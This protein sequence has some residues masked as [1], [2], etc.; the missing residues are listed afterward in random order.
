MASGCIL[1]LSENKKEGRLWKQ[2]Q[3]YQD[4]FMTN[5][6]PRQIETAMLPLKKTRRCFVWNT[7]YYQLDIYTS[8]HPGLMLLETYTRLQPDQLDLP[9]FLRIDQNVTG[10]PQYSMFNLSK[11]E[12]TNPK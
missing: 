12:N 9:E 3:T 2:E 4:K 10:D 1:I 7:Q 6:S 8:P 5:Y 11:I